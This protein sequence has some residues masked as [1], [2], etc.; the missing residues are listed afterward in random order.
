MGFSVRQRIIVNSA[1]IKERQYRSNAL[2]RGFCLFLLMTS[3]LSLAVCEKTGLAI[4]PVPRV[5]GWGI[6]VRNQRFINDTAAGITPQNIQSLRTK[7]VFALPDTDAP[8]FLPLIT[9]NTVV[10]A[11]GE[12]VVYALARDN[13]CE[14]W[15]FDAD[16]MVRTALRYVK[17][18]NRHLLVFGTMDAHVIALDLLTGKQHWKT[19]ASGHEQAM[20][21]GSSVDHRGVIYQAVSSWE[22][23]WAVNPFHGCCT[24]RGPIVALNAQTGALKWQAHTIEVEP[25]V[26]QARWLLPDRMGP[27]GAPVWSQPTIDAAR[28]VL[29]VGTGEN[30][31]S[32]ATD[33]SDAI[34]AFDLDT[35]A[36]R[37]KQ[38]LLANDAWNVSCELPFDYNCPAERGMD[39]DFGAPP[40]LATFND[41][42]YIIAG[43][44]SGFVYALEPDANGK[45]LWRQKAGNGGKAGG[46]H[47]ALAVDEQRGR[48]YA[49]IS[50]RDV[51]FYGD[52]PPGE[53]QPSLKAYNIE[54]GELLWNTK[55]P[56][57][58]LDSKGHAIKK[59]FI[60]FSAAP[61]ATDRVVFAPTLD[62]VIRAFDASTGEALWQ[63]NT[64]REFDAV[65]ADKAQGGTIDYGGVFLDAGELFVSSGYGM[66]GQMDGN[67]FIVMSVKAG[68]SK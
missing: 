64:L 15:R 35:G 53:P 44:K 61:T 67:A 6:D 21:S 19:L 41:K 31:S 63:F 34:L 23:A 60:G 7:W 28:G 55:A 16:S 56:G 46:V 17:T 13:G 20:V 49:P 5:N 9:A 51:G 27:S 39:L 54:T 47:F 32:P 30:Y 37:W 2:L 29:Y 33:T 38:Q 3:P 59:C 65:N 45:E 48:V 66:V 50:D 8:R 52:N 24:F 57:D 26:H 25:V 68:E 62:G 42:D 4:D 40:V 1:F 22:L 18:P 10:I 43:Q 36:M 14:I 12:G 58:C 11:D